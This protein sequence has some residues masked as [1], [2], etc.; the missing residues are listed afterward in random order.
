MAYPISLLSGKLRTSINMRSRWIRRRNNNTLIYVYK[1]NVVLFLLKDLVNILG[2]SSS[3]DYKKGNIKVMSGKAITLIIALAH[4]LWG[5]GEECSVFLLFTVFD[6]SSVACEY[7]NMH[8]FTNRPLIF[9]RR[10]H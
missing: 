6:I 7:S 3:Y 10:H 9:I 1:C 8:C 2:V 5:E 4:Y